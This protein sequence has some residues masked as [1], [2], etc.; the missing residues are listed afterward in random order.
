MMQDPK[1]PFFVLC[2]VRICTQKYIKI[3]NKKVIYYL[4]QEEDGP[5]SGFGFCC[6]EIKILIRGMDQTQNANVNPAVTLG[7][8]NEV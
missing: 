3:K 8:L 1:T 7:L 5:C 2:V 6:E 4:A